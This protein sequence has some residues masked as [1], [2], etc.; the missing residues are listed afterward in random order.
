MTKKHAL[1]GG[2]AAW[3]AG[4][5]AVLRF[6]LRGYDVVALLLV[7]IAALVL[8]WAFVGGAAF[9]LAAS[10]ACA[11]ALAVAATEVPIVANSHTDA[12]DD[13]DY[14]VV[15]GARV[16][17]DGQP[18]YSLRYRLEAALAYLE[19][20][21]ATAAVLSGGQG[22]DEPT[23]E[24][25]CMYGWLVEHGVEVSRLLLEGKSSN[26]QENLR[27]SFALI[28]VGE[29]QADGAGTVGTVGGEVEGTSGVDDTPAPSAA[30]PA[31]STPRIAVVSSSYHLFRAKLIARG[32]G[33]EVLG[34]ASYPG[35]PVVALN[36][37]VREAPAVWKQLL[38]G[39]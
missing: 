19:A 30:A 14:L 34:V 36:Y 4:V 37:F 35:N 17:E 26:T 29:A 9:K 13:A 28:G 3:L 24:A 2:I 31:P 23:T 15:L 38:M 10:L 16:D 7:L 8:L 18:S 12:G 1:S 27:N 21:P 25:A 11:L 33:V 20:H 39:S 32:L 22:D 5:A 6:A